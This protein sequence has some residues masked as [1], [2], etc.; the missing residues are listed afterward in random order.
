MPA[1]ATRL[2]QEGHV[3]A[4]IGAVRDGGGSRNFTARFSTPPEPPSS[5]R[6]IWPRRW[7]RTRSV[8]CGC[9]EMIEAWGPGEFERLAAGLL[10][11]GERRTRAAL[12]R[13]PA[14]V[15][16]FS[17]LMEWGDRDVVIAV[18]I[19]VAD[20]ELLADF[21]GTDPQVRATST[22]SRR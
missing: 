10:D 20:G 3:V 9:A 4:P 18:A 1:D 13:L 7:G 22:P 14:G 21:T 16:R 11:Y 6:A 2:E 5:E 12:G 15:Y 17:D 19:T 8:R